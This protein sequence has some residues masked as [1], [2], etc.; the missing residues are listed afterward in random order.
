MENIFQHPEFIAL[1]HYSE[2]ADL[3]NDYKAGSLTANE[4]VY[5]ILEVYSEMVYDGKCDVGCS[6]VS[7]LN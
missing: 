6:W 5:Q 1:L 2:V 3:Y 7:F 4:V